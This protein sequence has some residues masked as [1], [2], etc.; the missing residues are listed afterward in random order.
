MVSIVMPGDGVAR[1]GGDRVGGHRR[2]EE[3]EDEGEED[4][5]QHDEQRA[6]QAGE[7]DRDAASVETTT[8]PEDPHD[9]HVAV[10]ALHACVLSPWRKAWPRWRTSPAT[11]FSDFTMPKMPAVAIAPTPMKRT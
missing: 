3:G 1:G 2:E 5:D 7:E 10:G 9:R 4:A 8:P 11:T 6:A